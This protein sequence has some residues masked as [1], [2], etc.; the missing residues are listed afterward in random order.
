MHFSQLFLSNPV[1]PHNFSVFHALPCYRD[2]QI[3]IVDGEIVL[4]HLND[5]FA[6]ETT[7]KIYEIIGFP[8]EK[9]DHLWEDASLSEAITVLS[10]ILLTPCKNYFLIE[11][12]A[13]H[14]I[15]KPLQTLHLS[16][17]CKRKDTAYCVTLH[18]HIAHNVRI[19]T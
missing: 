15:P 13:E 9:I 17:L 8:T 12:Y 1:L 7:P 16:G 3:K 10:F 4:N 18:L 6:E 2:Y 5:S 11:G 19:T 14:V